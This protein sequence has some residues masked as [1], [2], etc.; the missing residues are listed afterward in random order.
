MKDKELINDE[1]LT[2]T[3]KRI[4]NGKTQMF[5]EKNKDDRTSINRDNSDVILEHEDKAMYAE[6]FDEKWYW[7]S[8]CAECNGK[9]RDWM[10]Y[11]ECEKHDRC[12]SCS[13]NRKVPLAARDIPIEFVFISKESK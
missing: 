9:E 1:R 12:S 4:R 2:L 11:V 10:S 5:R 13:I 8:G 6:L 7:V 3:M